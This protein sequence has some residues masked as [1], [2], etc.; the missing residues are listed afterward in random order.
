[1][2]DVIDIR[3]PEG[4][5][6]DRLDRVLAHAIPH[7]SR[8]RLQ[9][10]IRNGAVTVD[11]ATIRE[12]RHAVKPGALIGL[13]VPEPEPAAPEP[14]PIPLDIVHEDTDVIVINKPAGLVVHPA[15]GHPNNTLVNAL[16][17]HCGD[18]LSGI[19]GVK[20]PGIV[21]RLDRDTSGLMVAAKTETAHLALAEQFS[22]HGRSGPLERAYLAMVWGVPRPASG[23]IEAAIGRS[24]H[25]ALKQ[26]VRSDGKHAGTRYKLVSCFYKEPQ[27][28]RGEA[29]A[30][31][32]E[33][34]LETGRTHQIRV[35]MAHLGHPLLGDSLYGA[36]YRTK[37]EALPDEAKT[38]LTAMNGQAL[39]AFRLGFDHPSSGEHMVFER[40]PRTAM[41]RLIRAFPPEKNR[42]SSGRN[43]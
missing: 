18:T 21:H 40:P 24:K 8:S 32:I 25:N 39:H 36:G 23:R 27:N 22:D 42:S 11:G 19:G 14:Q 26:A 28:E 35:H 4:L 10:L 5:E 17:A 3:V 43:S 2:D 34:R 38:A 33:C 16:I 41:A 12:P 30:S 9:T 1:M 7:L 13:T 6:R 37:I 15:P 31:L 29:V 20:R